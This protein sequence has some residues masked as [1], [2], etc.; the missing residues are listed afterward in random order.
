MTE[1]IH[2]AGVI[3]IWRIVKEKHAKAA[4]TGEGARLYGGRWN[5][6]GISVIYA[7]Q[8]QSLAIL[9]TLVH[10]DSPE[11]LKKYVLFGVEVDAALVSR[12]DISHLSKNWKDNPVPIEVQAI[13]DNWVESRSSAVLLVPSALVPEE[14]NFLLNP[15]HPDFAKLKI[16]KPVAFQFDFASKHR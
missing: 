4:F 10:L 6:P 14:S 9:E 16:R 15:S 8:S 7:A 3:T 11:L 13:G 1:T 5:S 2:D 12:L